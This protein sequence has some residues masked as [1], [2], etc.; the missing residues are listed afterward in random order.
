[1]HTYRLLGPS[2]IVSAQIQ[3]LWVGPRVTISKQFPG[4]ADSQTTFG[5][6]VEGNPEPLRG[7]GLDLPPLE[8][9]ASQGSPSNTKFMRVID[10]LPL[11][12][13]GSFS[14]NVCAHSLFL[15]LIIPHILA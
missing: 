7:P 14:F 12:I 9:T 8:L 15:I 1:M 5:D 2:L 11:R 10:H 4:A 3:E 13:W 6:S